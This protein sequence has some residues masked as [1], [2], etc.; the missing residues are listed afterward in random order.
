MRN[1][2]TRG[3]EISEFNLIKVLLQIY[4]EFGGKL[5]LLVNFAEFRRTNLIYNLF[6][7]HK[8]Q[9]TIKLRDVPI[10]VFKK[11]IRSRSWSIQTKKCLCV[12]THIL[13]ILHGE[14]N[15]LFQAKINGNNVFKT[16]VKNKEAIDKLVLGK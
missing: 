6:L 3:I 15:L 5:K 4:I 7:N 13:N 11:S 16:P 10:K 14:A 1:W 2:K 9:W 12:F 8:F